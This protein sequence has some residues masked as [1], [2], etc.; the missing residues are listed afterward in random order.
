MPNNRPIKFDQVEYTVP[1]HPT[2]E[3]LPPWGLWFDG[4]QMIKE[5][6]EECIEDFGGGGRKDDACEY[7][8]EKL[9]F[10]AP[11]WLVREHLSGYGAWDKQELCDHQQNL[12]RLLWVHASDLAE[13]GDSGPLYLMR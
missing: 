11:P 6:P 5:L 10:D 7:W 8:V 4:R 2:G 3:Y 1:S 9:R 12:K 13:N